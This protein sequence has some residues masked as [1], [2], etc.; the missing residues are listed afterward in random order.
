MKCPFRQNTE[1]LR[2]VFDFSGS[3]WA[4][5]SPE[6]AAKIENTFAD[7]YEDECPAYINGKCIKVQNEVKI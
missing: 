2:E 6:K 4:S 5:S 1:Y 7:C 3:H